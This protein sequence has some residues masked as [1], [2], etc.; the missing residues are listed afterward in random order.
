MN[1]PTILVSSNQAQYDASQASIVGHGYGTRSSL[2]AAAAAA[3]GGS[4]V[5]QQG[6]S[7]VVDRQPMQQVGSSA[8][9]DSVPEAA[10]AP[11]AACK[12]KAVN[13]TLQH[14]ANKRSK[15]ASQCSPGA[16]IS[17][18]GRRGLDDGLQKHAAADGCGDGEG[19]KVALDGA[20]DTARRRPVLRLRKGK[21]TTS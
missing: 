11:S 1:S 2:S 20:P 19:D 7:S 13:G 10:E 6:A 3:G 8:D 15:V 16:V 4:Q 12:R 5:V 9:M 14:C 17:K 21:S 18:E